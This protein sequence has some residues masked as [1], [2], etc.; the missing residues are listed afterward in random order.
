MQG[1]GKWCYKKRTSRQPLCPSQ[2]NRR[3]ISPHHAVF[4][5]KTLS[6]YYLISLPCLFSI[7]NY[8]ENSIWQS[9]TNSGQGHSVVPWLAGSSRD[10]IAEQPVRA[11]T[12][13]EL[14]HLLRPLRGLAGMLIGKPVAAYGPHSLGGASWLSLS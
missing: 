11:M 8:L 1:S 3:W 9:L 7:C 2:E 12:G 6:P 4:L 14:Y 5:L 10:Q 13:D